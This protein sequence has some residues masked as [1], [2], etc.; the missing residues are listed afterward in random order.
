M[1]FQRFNRRTVLIST[2][3]LAGCVLL[4][5]AM[6]IPSL[7]RATAASVPSTGQAEPSV[8]VVTTP[9]RRGEIGQPVVA[10]GVVGTA[11]G[12]LTNVSL[13]YAAKVEEIRVQPGQRV[14]RGE[15][16]V[17][18]QAD[19]AAV[20]AAAQAISAV[21]LAQGELSRTQALFEQALA[22]RSQL[23]A[24]QKA[25]SDAEATH[26][27]QVKLGVRGG[28]STVVS[29]IDAV[30]LQISSASGDQVPAGTA[31]LQLAN[32][33]RTGSQPA[34]IMLGVE[35]AAAVNI[36][37]GDALT[38]QGLDVASS[39]PVT[40]GTVV[41]VGHAIDPQSQFVDVSAT[42]P[43]AQS[44]LIPGTHVRAAIMTRVGTHWIV[45]RDTVLQDD[46]ARYVFQL[47]ASGR[48]HRVPVTISVENGDDY[49]VEGPLH[50]SQPLVA[51]GND[52][53]TEGMRARVV[54]ATTTGEGAPR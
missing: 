19:T 4:V 23:A 3:A 16:L 26:A 34:N 11:M 32:S 48:A 37:P 18:V 1:T 44:P 29:P 31:M 52:E 5:S 47:D 45:P 33:S 17:V 6:L 20:A 54:N 42:I 30:V 49:G 53:L 46:Q 14:V 7:T 41:L 25:L 40:A 36:H 50:T 13:P 15:P 43:L 24:A 51:T 12:N 9:L 35:P 38:A 39:K 8:A 27:A 10:Y 21:Q 28:P 2:I 22:T